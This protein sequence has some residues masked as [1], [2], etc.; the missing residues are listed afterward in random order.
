M[1]Q[2]MDF[3]MSRNLGKDI[4]RQHA[5]QKNNTVFQNM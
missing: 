5:V 1:S 4:G 2:M 3:A